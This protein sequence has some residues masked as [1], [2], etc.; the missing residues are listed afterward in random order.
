MNVGVIVGRF[1]NYKLHDGYHHLINEVLEENDR[2]II[3]IGQSLSNLED[4]N[5]IPAE[6]IKQS[7]EQQLN[8]DKI[9]YLILPDCPS[10]DFVWTIKLDELI[11]LNTESTDYIKLYGSRDSF[12]NTYQDYGKYKSTYIKDIPYI[13]SSFLRST[14]KP[15]L[16]EDF[17]KGMIYAQNVRFPIVYSTVDCMIIRKS[18]LF[19]KQILLGLKNNTQKWCIPGGF[20]DRYEHSEDAIKRELSEE[21]PHIKYKKLQYIRDAVIA[22]KRYLDTKDSILTHLYQAEYVSGELIAGDDLDRL[23]FFSVKD[24]QYILGNNH[25]HFLKFIK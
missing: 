8:N 1:Q 10:D 14:V 2:V 5:P 7:I 22:D 17:L 9:S 12:L 16:S 25:K 4:R 24:A 18:W 20:I 15:V 3:I 19:G 23:E 13:S 11:T 21:C 6:L